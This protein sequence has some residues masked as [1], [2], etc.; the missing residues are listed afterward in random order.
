MSRFC[1]W[2]RMLVMFLQSQEKWSPT[3][4][5][6]SEYSVAHHLT[7][8]IINDLKVSCSFC[9]IVKAKAAEIYRLFLQLGLYQTLPV[10]LNARF[11]LKDLTPLFSCSSS[12]PQAPKCYWTVIFTAW[13]ILLVLRLSVIK[14]KNFSL[15]YSLSKKKQKIDWIGRFYA[16]LEGKA[17][18]AHCLRTE[19]NNWSADFRMQT[20]SYRVGSQ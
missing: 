2:N 19:K 10:P 15:R 1:C 9:K 11:P 12:L 20:R 5:A 13:T 17:P 14:K 3:L 7:G 16:I 6:A 18:F 4:S 8:I